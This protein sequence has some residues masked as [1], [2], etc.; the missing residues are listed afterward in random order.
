MDITTMF[1]EKVSQL[2]GSAIRE[3]FKLMAKPG[4]ISFAGGSD[5]KSV[6]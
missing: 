6:V 1:S 3:M 2:E 5:R 4:M